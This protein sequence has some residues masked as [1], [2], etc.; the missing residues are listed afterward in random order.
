MA[1]R[2]RAERGAPPP[3]ALRP[4]TRLAAL[5][6]LAAAFA[7][8]AAA[9]PGAGADPTPG[10]LELVGSNPLLDR[11]MN[12]ALAVHGD[13]AYVGSRTDGTHPNAGV[14]VV[15]I[16]DPSDPRVVSQI[17]APEEGNPGESSRELRVWPRQQL[18][19]VENFECEQVGH[20]CAGATGDIPPSFRFYDISGDHAADPQ[21]V[22]TYRPP[23]LPHEF[24]LWEDPERPQR[25]LLYITSPS[26][27]EE[28]VGPNLTVV[29]ISD[30]REGQFAELTQFSADFT[31]QNLPGIPGLHSLSLSPDGRTAYVAYLEGGFLVLDT[32]ELAEARDQPQIHEI[33][34]TANTVHRMRP[35]VHSALKVPDLPMALISDEV[36]GSVFGLGPTLGF[37]V[38]QGCPWGWS[39]M[40]DIADP[41][42][43]RIIG[44]YKLLPYND[45]SYCPDAPPLQDAGSSFSPHNPTV[46]RHLALMTWHS[47]GFQLVSIDDPAAPQQLAAFS[48]EPVPVVET[49]DP[50]LS[51]GTEKVVMWSYPVVQDGLIYVVDLRNGLYVLRYHGPFD[52]DLDCT[53]F[54]EGNSNLTRQSPRCGLLLRLVVKSRARGGASPN[55]SCGRSGA[56]VRL[57]GEDRDRVS[58]VRFSA[59]GHRLGVDG[60][61]PFQARVR[62]ERIRRRGGTR[63]EAVAVMLDGS[64]IRFHGFAGCG[65]RGVSG[66]P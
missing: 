66:T 41:R 59:A 28:D 47:G 60:A 18:L 23:V 56:R 44:E 21:L 29:D 13:F 45:P 4:S 34:P 46:T 61:A 11:G 6:A 31:G 14:L 32:S 55:R 40:V 38:L 63:V 8:L 27:K 58:K 43:P 54:L 36:Y 30:A 19:I 9:P 15:D 25:A 12:A 57:R 7:A 26:E 37:D 48:P 24:F 22:S 65:R 17:G 53:R 33:T 5:A 52:S 3:G 35:G 62:R 39:H 51:S 50:A 49:E 10:S 42:T 16:S 2:L 64:R 20:A 1:V